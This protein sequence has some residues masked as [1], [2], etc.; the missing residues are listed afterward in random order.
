MALSILH[1]EKA[2]L[3]LFLQVLGS[4]AQSTP[5]D[6][7]P[8]SELVYSPFRPCS[9]SKYFAYTKA[10]NNACWWWAICLL[11]SADEARK[12]QFA[13]ISL[14]MGLVPLTLKDIAW[15]ERRVVSV[16]R[17][18]PRKIEVI[19]RALG[20]V[21]SIDTSSY[22]ERQAM[23]STSLYGRVHRL[24]PT[25]FMV[26]VAVS[27]MGLALTYAGLA[28]MEVYSKRSSLGCPY[29][30]FILT[31]H[32]FAIIPA[33]I[34]TL[35]RHG[36]KNAQ[37]PEAPSQNLAKADTVS[38]KHR[39]S[40]QPEH[41][42]TAA[43]N[44]PSRYSNLSQPADTVNVGEIRHRHPARTKRHDST[45]AFHPR[46]SFPLED[47]SPVQGRGKPWIVQLVWGIYYVAGTLVYSSIMAVTV[48]ELFV[49]VMVTVAVTASSKLLAFF[50]CLALEKRW[51]F[52]Q[53]HGT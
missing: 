13:A 9:Q 18:L 40:K 44:E 52:A 1:I 39:N 45:P 35:F 15:P 36:S 30:V 24:S 27:A 38:A 25:M 37:I 33:S 21:P 22:A 16:S 2:L 41:Q 10:T 53:N 31:W 26:L 29:P 50:S 34:E 6:C 12:Q 28:V 3:A 8:A 49:W 11:S 23:S 32:L 19:I 20:L 51:E 46:A 43:A 48:I 5:V 7:P 4:G 14:V 42:A 17:Q 47:T